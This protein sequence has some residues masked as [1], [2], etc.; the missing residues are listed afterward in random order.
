[1]PAVRTHA[2]SLRTSLL[3]SFALLI[4]LS[5]LTVLVLMWVRSLEVEK[6]LSGR[7][8]GRGTERA[9]RELEAFL[10]EAQAF[11]LHMRVVD[12]ADHAAPNQR[13]ALS[14]PLDDPTARFHVDI[15]ATVPSYPELQRQRLCVGATF[16]ARLP[17]RFVELL[18]VVRVQESGPRGVG[19]RDLVD[20]ITEIG[21][22]TTAEVP[23]TG[24]DV[25]LPYRFRHRVHCRLVAFLADPQASLLPC[26]GVDPQQ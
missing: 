2:V 25:P 13:I 3:R 1:M 4:L 8:T 9:S 17:C 19:N 6:D 12:V 20:G 15:A 18:P 11:G 16:L 26:D 10:A 21:E 23:F 22:E 7:L 14:I 24:D 5:S